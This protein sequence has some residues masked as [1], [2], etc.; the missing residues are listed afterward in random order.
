MCT[1]TALLETGAL[2][3]A[4][5]ETDVRV[6]TAVGPVQATARLEGGRV[7]WVRVRNVPSFALALDRK[8]VVP[9]YGTT[10][11]TSPSAARCTCRPAPLTW[12]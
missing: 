11:R 9:E 3:C 10:L 1:V 12:E 7:R 5:P 2:P 6:D 4:E 8:I